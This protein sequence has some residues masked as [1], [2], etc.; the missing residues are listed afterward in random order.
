MQIKIN[1][2]TWSGASTLPRIITRPPAKNNWIVSSASNQTPALH[3]YV[4]KAKG[5]EGTGSEVG[6]GHQ[7][8][9]GRSVPHQRL[10]HLSLK[11]R[12]FALPPTI[13]F[14]LDCRSASDYTWAVG[15]I[16]LGARAGFSSSLELSAK[17]KASGLSWSASMST[18]NRRMK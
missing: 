9:G 12:R 18:Y 5:R 15:A 17:R 4:S 10:L 3:P 1:F 8:W 14:N 7:G 11:G 16:N 13:L 6:S 2:K